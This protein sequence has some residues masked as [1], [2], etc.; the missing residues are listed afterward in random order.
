MIDS[1]HEMLQLSGAELVSC[2][3][4]HWYFLRFHRRDQVNGRAGARM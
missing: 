2:H 4:S 3:C 1:R